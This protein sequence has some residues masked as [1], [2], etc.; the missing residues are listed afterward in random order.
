[1]P[2]AK[3]IELTCYLV[4]GK[5]DRWPYH[6]VKRHTLKQPSLKSGERALRLVIK[7]D[8][9]FFEPA[10]TPT[11]FLDVPEEALSPPTPSVGVTD[12]DIA[13]GQHD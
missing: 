6:S 13:E 9:S 2:P 1:M 11:V 3:P 5:T 4:I 12:Y 7:T 8:K 10:A